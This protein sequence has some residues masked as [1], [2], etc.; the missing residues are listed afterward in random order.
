MGPRTGAVVRLKEQVSPGFERVTWDASLTGPL[1][2]LSRKEGVTLFVTALSAFKALLG[3]YSGQEE[4]VVGARLSARDAEGADDVT[5]PIQHALVLRTDLDGDP[6]F[7]ELLHRVRKATA[8]AYAQ[9]HLRVD[10]LEATQGPLPGGG[11]LFRAMFALEGLSAQTGPLPVNPAAT[12]DSLELRIGRELGG[13][14]GT[15][16][17]DRA[18]GDERAVAAMLGHFQTLVA[19]IVAEPDARLSQLPLLTEAER[20]E[21]LVEWSGSQVRLPE[22]GACIHEL[23]EAQAVRAPHALAVVATEGTLTYDELNRQANRLAHQLRAMGVGPETLVGFCFERSLEMLVGLFGILKAGGAYVP[24]DP[25]Y[26]TERL[27]FM[28][29]DANVPVL[30]TQT[31]LLDRFPPHDARVACL[32]CLPK[33]VDRAAEQPVASGVTPENLAYVIYTSGSTGTPKGTLTTHQSMVKYAQV[34]TLRFGIEPGDRILQYCSISF[35]ISVEEIFLSLTQGGTLVLRTPEMLGSVSAFLQECER[36]SISVLS[37]PTAF[38]HEIAAKLG[39]EISTLPPSLGV[40]IIGGE[41]VQPERLARWSTHV[42]RRPRLLNTYGLTEASVLSTMYDLTGLTPPRPDEVKDVPIGRPV[43]GVETY[44]LDQ[45]LQP[46]PIGVPG[47]LCIGG[48][49]LARG[50]LNLPAATAERFVSSPFTAGGRSNRLYRTGDLVRY[51]PDRQIEYIGRIDQQVKIRGFRVEPGEIEA[52]LNQH[53]GA[54]EA[55]V[56]ARRD[57]MGRNALIA[58]IVPEP[59]SDLLDSD[60]RAFLKGRLPDYMIPSA[61]VTLE[62]LPLSP[63]GKV[64]R[65]ALPSPPE[66]RPE[67]EGPRAEPRTDVERFI[68]ETWRE[69]LQIGGVSI[70]DNFFDLGGYS[71]LLM[72]AIGRIEAKLG[73]TLMP[74]DF[75]VQTLGQIAAACEEQMKA[76]T[77]PASAGLLRRVL[78]GIRG[79]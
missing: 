48:P 10:R 13:L 20:Y 34:A 6:T 59:Q 18:L 26:P 15:L 1:E 72:G 7:R 39:G 78:R 3:R 50:Y 27:A 76:A 4:I 77:K 51:G 65:G 52:L 5:G 23:F 68:A 46:V 33:D 53:P 75:A 43:D 41:R 45:H 69:A 71:L 30:L 61:F 32:D 40:V 49:H 79:R 12:P 74:D 58:Y 56:V 44:V 31:A 64:D 11:R 57:D 62:S 35:D 16:T 21:L 67:T 22:S 47:E 14:R 73:I 2:E 28:L 9:R 37:L 70:Y 54:S 42:G 55:V 19:G 63:N 25:A 29:K 8:D 38:W 17:Y 66:V 36:L 24:L 60:L